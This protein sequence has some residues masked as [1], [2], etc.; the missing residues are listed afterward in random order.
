MYPPTATHS[1]FST[2]GETHPI[3][4]KVVDPMSHTTETIP[5]GDSSWP[6][7]PVDE[8]N[9]MMIHQ[10]P[11]SLPCTNLSS[12]MASD[13]SLSYPP[14]DISH[15]EPSGSFPRPPVSLSLLLEH[16]PDLPKFLSHP[17]LPCFVRLW[18]QFQQDIALAKEPAF[19][20]AVQ[21]NLQHLAVQAEGILQQIF[22]WQ[23]HQGDPSSYNDPESDTTFML[24]ALCRLKERVEVMQQVLQIIENGRVWFNQDPKQAVMPILQA[25]IKER[26]EQQQV[27]AMSV[28]GHSDYSGSSRSSSSS[29]SN[30]A[31]AA[32]TT[33]SESISYIHPAALSTV[34]D[35]VSSST[36]PDAILTI[37]PYSTFTDH[38]AVKENGDDIAVATFGAAVTR[39]PES[40]DQVDQ[41]T[42]VVTT[43]GIEDTISTLSA[44]DIDDDGDDTE[45]EQPEETDDDDEYIE[46][47]PRRRSTRRRSTRTHDEEIDDLCSLLGDQEGD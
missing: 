44:M 46:P 3:K 37:E 38:V 4:L 25:V 12:P 36:S 10:H 1:A 31:A 29:C 22:Y 33:M 42:H 14:P 19:R 35:Q 28:G 26:Q 34:N 43:D 40:V 16:F 5:Y 8:S 24:T 20:P 6:V 7:T 18:Y 9:I 41:D 15:A 13:L 30:D 11:S 17:Q 32:G 39:K 23:H 21:E 27:Q 45:Y 47:M 2:Y